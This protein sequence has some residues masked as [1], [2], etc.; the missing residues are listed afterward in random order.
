MQFPE[1]LRQHFV[2]S[3]DGGVASQVADAWVAFY[4]IFVRH[5]FGNFRDVLR[6]VTY[7]PIM[8]DFL[9]FRG[10]SA[11]DRDGKYPDEN[12]A[13]EVMQLFTIGLWELN[14]DGSRKQ[15]GFGRDIPTY[16]NDNV[17]DF[18]RVFTGFDRQAWR[19]NLEIDKTEHNLVDPMKMRG[20]VWHDWYPKMDLGQNYIG[21]GYPLC[22]DLPV[23]HF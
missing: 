23:R 17:M 1:E 3:A 20:D 14:E 10:N 5:A 13:R 19:A 21:D 22:E 12:Y 15:D 18:A 7:S 2:A 16:T 9:T 8:G 6:E 4:D 11:Y